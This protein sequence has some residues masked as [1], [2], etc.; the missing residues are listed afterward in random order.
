MEQSSATVE[1]AAMA[2]GCEPG[3]IAKTMSFFLNGKAILIVT[4]GDVKIDNKKYKDYFHEKAK[5]IPSDQVEDYVGHAPGGVCPF[6]INT[7][8]LVYLD[9]SLKRFETIYPAGGSANSAVKLSLNELETFSS[10]C[11]WV[12]ICKV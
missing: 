4:A 2:I 3:L 1:Q 7:D 5:M 12:D 9:V 11:G 10:A 8:V 6:N